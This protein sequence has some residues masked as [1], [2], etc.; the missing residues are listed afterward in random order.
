MINPYDII[1]SIFSNEG[2]SNEL[3]SVKFNDVISVKI[4]QDKDGNFQVSF[5]ESK[6]TITVRRYLTLSLKVNGILL[7]KDSGVFQIDYFPDL[8]FKYNWLFGQDQEEISE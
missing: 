5:L 4:E 6:P 1:K 2:F 3:F 7:R 8:P